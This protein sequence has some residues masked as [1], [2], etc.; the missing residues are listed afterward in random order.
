MQKLTCF[1]IV[2]YL[3]FLLLF[4][5]NSLKWLIFL[6]LFATILEFHFDMSKTDIVVEP[7]TAI[8]FFPDKMKISAD[9]FTVEGQTPESK[10]LVSGKLSPSQI[11]QLNSG[12]KVK[13]YDLSG[14]VSEI[15]PASNYGQFDQQKYYWGKKITQQ[16][17]LTSF[18]IQIKKGGFLNYL[19]YWR[20]H[21]KKFLQ[22]LPPILSFFSN[23]L[24]LGESPDSK[25]QTILNNYRDLGVIHILSISGLHVGIYTLAIST[26][27]YYSKLTE[28]ETFIFC[29]FTLLVGIFLSNGQAGFIRASLTFILGQ[30][31]SLTKLKIN[32][33][34]LLGLTAILHLTVNPRLM[35]STGA[36]LSYSLAL[37]LEM[38]KHLSRFKQSLALNSL[39]LPLLLFYFFQFNLLTVFFNLLIVPYFN[40]IVMPLTF[41]NLII[42]NIN[43]RYSYF[44]EKILEQ[45]EKIIASVSNSKIGLLTFG[46]INWWQCLLLLS[47]TSALLVLINE[48]PKRQKSIRNIFKLA[49]IMYGLI[50]LTIHFPLKGQVTFIDVGQGDSILISTPF[51]RQVYLIDVGG[52]L[53]FNG[54]KITPQINKIT[55]PF[56]KAQGINKIDGIFISHQDADHVGDLRPLL[57]QIRVKKLYMAKGLIRNPSFRKRIA[58]HVQKDQ[59]VQLLAGKI[60]KKPHISFKVVYPFK[61]GIG[62][63]EDSL[64]I[65]FR[66]AN[67]SWLFTG[68]LGQKGELEIL[69][70]YHLHADY[71]KLGHH[72]SRTASNKDF[73]QALQPERVFISAGRKNRFGHP[74]PETIATLKSQ[75]IP[76]ASTQD[77]GMITWNYSILI[78]PKFKRFLPVIKK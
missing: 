70:R 45:G 75:H 30:I 9:W 71:F 28:K 13:L 26:L 4:K 64:S 72:G 67:K 16:V 33:A 32:K 47:L 42:F 21:V 69:S 40:W 53:N 49:L 34:D 68:D 17:K 57:S 36:L 62:K 18:K 10:I 51:F 27:C 6:I 54:K 58:G 76:W 22:K 38:T 59:I 52:R 43:P 48:K 60:I 1:L 56:L 11:Q 2:L 66:L 8:E 23:E 31:F 61:P 37:G 44:F 65:T 3:G 41:V 24:I 46:K 25:F 5:F 50:F 55:V 15:E 20:F 74:H 14:D 77:C 73:L 19:H 7:N 12:Y 39:L 78:K 63:N 35:L 29:L